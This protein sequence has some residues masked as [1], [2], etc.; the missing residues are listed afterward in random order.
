MVDSRYASRRATAYAFGNA[1]SVLV[2]L[3]LCLYPR[4]PDDDQPRLVKSAGS[5][6]EAVRVIA[7]GEVLQLMNVE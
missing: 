7:E 5:D 1:A 3:R 4:L 6:V 2:G